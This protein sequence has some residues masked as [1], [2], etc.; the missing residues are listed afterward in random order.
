MSPTIPIQFGKKQPA[1][2]PQFT[3]DDLEVLRMAKLRLE[4]PSFSMQIADL[5]G[6]PIETM[7]KMLPGPVRSRTDKLAF[8]ALVQSLNIAVNTLPQKERPGS[9]DRLH[10]WMGAGTGILGGLAG[11]WS[12]AVEL[13]VST[14]IIMR[15]IADIA[16]AEGHDLNDVETRLACVQVFALGAPSDDDDA[17]ESGYWVVRAGMSK[18]FTDAAAH[19]AQY[20]LS[21]EAGPPLVRFISAIS[22]RFT[23]DLSA[24]FAL[25]M[26]P[27][28][29]AVSAATVNVVFTRHFQ[30][31]A[32]GHFAIRRLEAKYGQEAVAEQYKAFNLLPE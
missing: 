4:S 6:Q 3:A 14:T 25:R 31:M 2:E 22:A 1:S 28:I 11:F 7:V 9:Q 24:H 29:S 17:A 30:E 27:V 20:G 5:I 15:S 8:A 18:A 26:I 19:A 12:L 21:R 16:A 10:R 32:K 13:P 23:A